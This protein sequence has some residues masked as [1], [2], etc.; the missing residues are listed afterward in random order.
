[1]DYSFLIILGVMILFMWLMSIP[2]KRQ[3][4]KYDAMIAA[5][6]AGDRVVTTARIYGEIISVTE[7]DVTLQI[8]VGSDVRIR[9]EKGGIGRVITDDNEQKDK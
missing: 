1:M 7:K 5:L 4:Q 2:S 6:K 3:R 9:M 8:G